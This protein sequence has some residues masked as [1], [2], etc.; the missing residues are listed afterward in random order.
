MCESLMKLPPIC[1]EMKSLPWVQV[2]TYASS[3][4]SAFTND[5]ARNF[6]YGNRNANS[7]EKLWFDITVYS[8]VIGSMLSS[9]LNW[10][11]YFYRGSMRI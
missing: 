1:K 7:A 8:V 10:P 3:D 4:L 11:G 2:V 5:R 6:V 9:N